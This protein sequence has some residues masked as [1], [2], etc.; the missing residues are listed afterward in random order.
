MPQISS[1]RQSVFLLHLTKLMVVMLRIEG[2]PNLK[3]KTRAFCRK[4]T[5]FANQFHSK[6]IVSTIIRKNHVNCRN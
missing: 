2:K 6:H 3:L 1:L 5:L 4:V